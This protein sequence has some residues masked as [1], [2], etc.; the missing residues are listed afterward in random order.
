MARIIDADNF[1]GDYPN[2]RF[3]LWP[4]PQDKAERIADILNEGGEYN[5]RIYKVVDNDY[6]LRP[7]FEP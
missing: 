1:D 5:Y 2:E 7:G 6:I 4:M 3:L